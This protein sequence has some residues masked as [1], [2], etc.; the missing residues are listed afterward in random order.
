MIRLALLPSL[1]YTGVR[2]P[3]FEVTNE[4][5][6]YAAQINHSIHWSSFEAQ[7]GPGSSSFTVSG[8]LKLSFS[9]C[10]GRRRVLLLSRADAC[11]RAVVGA[12]ACA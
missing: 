1:N 10:D 2:C 3:V 7:K 5:D 8:I 12:C 9:F 6:H 4:N 11:P